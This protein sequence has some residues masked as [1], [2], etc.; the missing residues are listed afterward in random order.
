MDRIACA[1]LIRRFIDADAVFKFLSDKD[2]PAYP[3][4]LRFD[5]DQAEFTH[6]SDKCSFEVLLEHV[7]I[8]NPALQ[9]IAEI[10]HDIDLKD[11]KFERDEAPGIAH[12]IADICVTQEDDL[13]RME[14]AGASCSTTRTN[15]S[16]EDAYA[17]WRSICLNPNRQGTDESQ[18]SERRGAFL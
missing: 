5:M 12:V 15:A 4:E 7:R 1:W 3:G 11:E 6:V 18:I 14:S 8:N 9:A 17:D 13:A 2:Y 16:R 10:I